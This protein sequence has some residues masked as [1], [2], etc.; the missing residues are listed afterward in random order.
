MDFDIESLRQIEGA[1]IEKLSAK[2]RSLRAADPGLNPG[3]ARAK[4]CAAMPQTTA[5]YLDA[6]QRLN[7]AGLQAKVWK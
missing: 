5:R 6:V 4:A 1:C 3:L 2:A 7:Y